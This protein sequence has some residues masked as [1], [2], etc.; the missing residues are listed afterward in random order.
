MK[1]FEQHMIDE[2][3]RPSSDNPQWVAFLVLNR[4]NPNITYLSHDGY[5]VHGLADYTKGISWQGSFIKDTRS[6]ALI[7]LTMDFDG[8]TT[9]YITNVWTMYWRRVIE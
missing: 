7:A 6:K 2:A 1:M 5:H 3:F 9:E 8:C 4:L